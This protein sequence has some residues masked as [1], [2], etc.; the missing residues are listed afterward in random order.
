MLYSIRVILESRLVMPLF[1][2]AVA[3]GILNGIAIGLNR[4]AARR[5]KIEEGV[6][7][8]QAEGDD[9]SRPDS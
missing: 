9:D 2:I 6:S 8:T 5:R 7:C 3:F 1:L 4:R